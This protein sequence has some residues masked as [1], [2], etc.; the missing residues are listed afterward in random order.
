MTAAERYASA[1]EVFGKLGV[2]TDAA[3]AKLKEVPTAL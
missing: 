3:L 1:K 2:D